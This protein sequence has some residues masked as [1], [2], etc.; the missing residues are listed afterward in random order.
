MEKIIYTLSRGETETEG[1]FAARLV[2]DVGPAL[3]SSG[4]LRVA[5]AVFDDEVAAAAPLRISNRVPPIDAVVSLWVHSANERSAWEAAL[6][7]NATDIA[8][9]L[10]AES[11]PLRDPLRP[12]DGERTPGMMQIACLRV[13]KGMQRDDW[14]RIWRDDHT[15]LAMDTQST[16]IYRQNLVARSLTPDAPE[17]AAIVEEAFPAAAMSS[18]H[19][20]YDA[21]GDDDK[22]ALNRTRMWESSK[23]FVEVTTID[24]LPASEYSWGSRTFSWK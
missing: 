22:L 14:F 16:F 4:A 9:Y 17:C 11:E 1:A 13:P 6:S 10:V 20:F 12:A 21:V 7:E 8:G 2:E 5:V 15:Q 18:Q 3:Y 23:R 19:A 24:V